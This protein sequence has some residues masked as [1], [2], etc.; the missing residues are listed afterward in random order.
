MHLANT[1]FLTE[2]GFAGP[3]ELSMLL[4]WGLARIARVKNG[5]EVRGFLEIDDYMVWRMQEEGE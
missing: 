4:K 5:Y 2:A 1:K 3:H